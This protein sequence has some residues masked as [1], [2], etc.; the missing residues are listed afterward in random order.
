MSVIGPTS[1]LED[2]VA[3]FEGAIDDGLIGQLRRELH[4]VAWSTHHYTKP[5]GEETAYDHEF[6]MGFS[7]SPLNVALGNRVREAIR[8]YL[9]IHEIGNLA[10]TSAPRL[11]RYGVGTQM[12]NH[13][14]SI[15]SLFPN[16]GV[17]H[18]SAVG[19]LNDDYEGGELMMWGTTEIPLPVGAVVVFP[20]SFM[21]QHSVKTIT[22]GE[23]LTCVVWGW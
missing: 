13:Y 18:I 12:R 8:Q 6:E 17:P 14:D 16:G 9:V 5:D 11:N 4:S 21:F 15:W 1:K 3:V 19:A 23:R 10:G 20:S 22:K 2:F 7:Y